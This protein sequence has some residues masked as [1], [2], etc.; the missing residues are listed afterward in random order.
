MSDEE[1]R[2]SQRKAAI[3]QM[4]RAAA[5]ADRRLDINEMQRLAQDLSSR[6]RVPTSYFGELA[7]SFH[8]Y[9]FSG[10]GKLDEV[11]GVMLIE[12]M[13]RAAKD[14]ADP[15]AAKAGMRNVREI[16]TKRMESA[17]QIKK[18]LGQGGQGAVYLSTDRSNGQEKVV[19]YYDKSCANAPSD[20]IIDEFALLTKLDH[21]KIARTYEIFQDTANIY[22]VSEPYFGGDLSTAVEK[23]QNSGVQLTE[24]WFAGIWRQACEGVAFLHT[25]HVMHCDIKEPNVMI[26]SKDNYREP[27]VVVIDF[28]LAQDFGAGSMPGGTPGYM[29]P[30][31]WSQGLW[32]PK[33]DT[34]AMGVMFWTM[35]TMQGSGPFSMGARS[36]EEV[37]ARTMQ[38]SI[39]R[40]GGHLASPAGR[41]MN[42]MITRML[43]KQFQ[44]RPTIAQVLQDPWMK[45][46]SADTME[47][48]QN[49]LRNMAKVKEMDDL[50]KGLMGVMA[51]KQNLAQLEELSKA[52]ASMD[53]DNDGM[54]TKD[55]AMN[56]L[57]SSGLGGSEANQLAEALIGDKGSVSY[58]VFMGQLIAAKK[59]NDVNMLREI[60]QEL[61]ADDNGY[62]DQ[63]EINAMLDKKEVQ[64]SMKGKNK[65]QILEEYGWAGKRHVRWED[66][67]AAFDKTT[68]PSDFAT[69]YGVGDKVEYF[70][71][72]YSRWVEA[73]VTQVRPAD[74]AIMLNVKPEYW[75]VKRDQA[76]K[77]R[78][79]GSGGYSSPGQQVLAAAMGM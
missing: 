27:N 52:F 75:F 70:S 63:N 4:F 11:E 77:I 3:A 28:G 79:P 23:A 1:V 62:L 21:P 66:F 8:R 56:A 30:E 48:D 69:G 7:L 51:T 71:A 6:L 41:N 35:I 45:S 15:K 12:G 53:D 34:F 20:D 72:S 58:T 68:S 60:F 24:G 39:P 38:C 78:K 19:K 32:T 67:R 5:G 2:K 22:V 59:G 54:V 25:Q 42:A 13:I 16:P 64:E 9:D 29:P 36:V 44:T 17:Y 65:T 61:D 46:A 10:D 31:V 33:G 47:L 73:Q 50:K 26:S 49:A 55:E 57:R 37:T 76:Q 40:V 18:K 74:G 14:R 43:G